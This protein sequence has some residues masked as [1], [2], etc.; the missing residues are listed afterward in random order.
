MKHRYNIGLYQFVFSLSQ[1]LDLINPAMANHHKRVAYIA[2]RLTEAVGMTG[3]SKEDVIVAAALHDVGSL[4]ALHQ[5]CEDCADLDLRYAR[6]GYRLLQ[7]FEPFRAPAHIVR[8]HNV[9][10]SWGEN[11]EI[12]NHE[13]PAGAHL[14]HLANR[15]NRLLDNDL[16]IYRQT[17]RIA[18]ELQALKG[19]ELMPEYVDAF[20]KL[21]SSDA[22]WLDLESPDLLQRLFERAPLSTVELDL[23][24]LLDFAELLAQLIDFRSR[25]T[26][27]HSSGVAATAATLGQLFGFPEV[28]CKR[29]QVAGYLH[30]IGKLAIPTEMLNKEGKL[31]D[32]EWHLMRSHPYYTYR[33]LSPITGLEDIAS[34]CGSHHERL[35]GEG[36]PFRTPHTDLPLE[37]RILA[38][39]DIFTALTENRP[40][41]SG[42]AEA[43]V[44][45]ILGE[46]VGDHALDGT[47]VGTLR[48]Y[49]AEINNSRA[50][51]QAHALQEYQSFMSG[52]GVLDLYGAC[53]VHL[54]WKQRLRAYLDGATMPDREQLMSHRNCELGNWYYGEGL[55][56]YGHIAEMSEL[57]TSHKE[58]HDLIHTLIEHFDQGRKEYAEECYRQIEPVSRRILALL[59][60]IENRALA[61]AVNT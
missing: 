25:F 58:L 49:Y 4:S 48:R 20:L 51:A 37:A 36:Y 52:L 24:G 23:D 43:Q 5:H 30:D 59:K 9:P 42:L 40:Y 18:E 45:E 39:A 56:Q 44:I 14:V 17:G 28:D 54:T 1:A 38:V 16:P 41:R 7:K 57:E 61:T 6:F 19:P 13:V 10:W 60:A 35:S 22:F 8:F 21:A 11:R 27:T 15:V 12:E 53:V 3:R 31:T 29:L 46:L 33:I 50:A 47:V 34:W 26:A 32:E 2:L 55:Q